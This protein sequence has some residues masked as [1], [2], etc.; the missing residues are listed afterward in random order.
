MKR[1]AAIEFIKN[2][3][4]DHEDEFN[5]AIQ[6]LDSYNGYLG[7]DRYYLMEDIDEIYHG[8]DAIEILS[9]AFYGYDETCGDGSSEPFNPNR[10][11]FRFNGYGNLVSCDYIDYSS[12]LDDYFVESYI[13]NA[14]NLYNVPDDVQEVVDG[15]EKEEE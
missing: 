11:Y 13:D 10:D 3:F 4:K 7:D 9:R 1:T 2:Y 5:E 8:T 15:I 6:E 12:F 14:Y